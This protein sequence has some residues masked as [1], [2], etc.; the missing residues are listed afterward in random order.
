MDTLHSRYV[1]CCLRGGTVYLVPVITPNKKMATPRNHI[2]MF[3]TPMDSMGEDDG[4]VRCV[5]SF[6]AGI[7]QVMRWKESSD[8]TAFTSLG[9]MPECARKSVAIMGWPGG[10]VDIYEITPDFS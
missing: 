1:A 10:N 5:Q 8:V 4:V 3:A 2:I 6:T 9:G 7:A